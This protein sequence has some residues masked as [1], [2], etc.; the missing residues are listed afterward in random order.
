M[1]S[2]VIIGVVLLV[3]SVGL[4]WT[5]VIAVQSPATITSVECLGNMCHLHITT[6]PA[7][8]F[9]TVDG[10]PGMT[11]DYVHW[12]VTVPIEGTINTH[13]LQCGD[14]MHL[15]TLVIK[16]DCA[17]GTAEIVSSTT[18]HLITGNTP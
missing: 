14:E 16:V 3:A 6:I 17:I 12:E 7:A 11:S 4:L 10:I 5:Q 1:N 9:L 13:V 15:H 8:G 18:L 2:N